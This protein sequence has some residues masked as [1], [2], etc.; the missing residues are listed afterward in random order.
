MKLYFSNIGEI[1]IL[2]NLGIRIY[3]YID[4]YKSIYINYGGT[5]A[6]EF[7]HSLYNQSNTNIHQD[8][9]LIIGWDIKNKNGIIGSC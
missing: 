1:K 4:D 9:H 8:K 3:Y 5:F 6:G 2:A 7:T